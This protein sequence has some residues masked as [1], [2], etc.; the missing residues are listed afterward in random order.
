MELFDIAYFAFDI[1]GQ[2]NIGGT[3][4]APHVTSVKDYSRDPVKK[5]IILI[6]N[7]DPLHESLNGLIGLLA[8]N[9]LGCGSAAKL[10]SVVR[11]LVARELSF[12]RLFFIQPNEALLDESLDELRSSA[13]ARVPVASARRIVGVALRVF[14][15][16]PKEAVTTCRVFELTFSTEPIDFLREPLL[17]KRAVVIDLLQNV[18][19]ANRS[20]ARDLLVFCDTHGHSSNAASMGQV[21]S[22][23]R[24]PQSG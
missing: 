12:V 3:F 23:V 21:S 1:D 10:S 8:M 5:E 16:Q 14:R 4:G 11:K 13:K 15:V 6:D 24:L 19:H 9:R 17:I 20:D 7:A 2:I 18:A 22:S